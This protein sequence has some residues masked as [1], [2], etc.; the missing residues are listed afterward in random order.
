VLVRVLILIRL[1][2]LLRVPVFTGRRRVLAVATMAIRLTMGPF[3]AIA[4]TLTVAI[5]RRTVAAPRVVATPRVVTIPRVITRLSPVSGL[6]LISR[7]SLITSRV[8]RRPTVTRLRAITSVAPLLITPPPALVL[9]SVLFRLVTSVAT[10]AV[11][12]R[13]LFA[14]ATRAGTRTH[15]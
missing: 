15:P 12:A 14:P 11:P 6:S 2:I 8:T 7:L 10:P 9:V 3:R 4:T 5:S 1:S 13:G